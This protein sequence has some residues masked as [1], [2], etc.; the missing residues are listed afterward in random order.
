MKFLQ[1]QI[2]V[3]LTVLSFHFLNAQQNA[4]LNFKKIELTYYEANGNPSKINVIAYAQINAY[5]I[6]TVHLNGNKGL[7]FYRYQLSDELMSQINSLLIG[8]NSLRKQ[9]VKTKMDV[10][11]HYAGSYNFIAFDK[12]ELCFVEPYMSKEFN[13]IFNQIEDIILKQFENAEIANPNFNIKGV[14]KRVMIEHKKSHYLPKIEQP[15]RMK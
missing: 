7:K 2:I 14:E 8:K 3:L 15:P 1:L 10:G 11:R 9:L 12:E 5:G 6:V 4:K 13:L